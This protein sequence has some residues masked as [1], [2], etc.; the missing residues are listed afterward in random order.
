MIKTKGQGSQKVSLLVVAL[1]F[2]M[3][4]VQGCCRLPAPATGI[5]VGK[6]VPYISDAEAVGSRLIS[7]EAMFV[8]EGSCPVGSRRGTISA[9]PSSVN[10]T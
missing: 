1:L 2:T 10:S 4:G 8:S 5:V 3:I 7:A 9:R 6:P